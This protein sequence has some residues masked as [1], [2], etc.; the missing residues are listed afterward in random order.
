MQLKTG[1]DSLDLEGEYDGKRYHV[2]G[3]IDRAEKSGSLL[4]KTPERD[5]TLNGYITKDGD[6]RITVEGNVMGA[7]SFIMVIK[8][9]YREAKLELTHKK[10]KYFIR[11][12]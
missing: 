10:A 4:V 7:V 9:N 2:Q 3:S 1:V 6:T 8:E 5:Y 12:G 11:E